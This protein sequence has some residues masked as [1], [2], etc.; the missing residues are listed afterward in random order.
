M[1]LASKQY[2]S[3]HVDLL[4]FAFGAGRYEDAATIFTEL[5]ENDTL[6]EF[7]ALLTYKQVA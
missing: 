5:A 6:V 7:L 2:R 3:V 1:L 4:G